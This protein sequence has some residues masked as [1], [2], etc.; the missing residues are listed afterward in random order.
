MPHIVLCGVGT[1]FFQSLFWHSLISDDECT[2]P[3][4]RRDRPHLQQYHTSR[5]TLWHLLHAMSFV[6]A[7]LPVSLLQLEHMYGYRTPPSAPNVEALGSGKSEAGDL[8][9]TSYNRLTHA[10]FV[11]M[12]RT[13]GVVRYTCCYC[14]I[15][16]REECTLHTCSRLQ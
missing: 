5:P 1:P 6:P 9:P 8:S 14:L 15:A 3:D 7:S 2:A 10:L 4:Q 12:A 11:V 13:G 16:S